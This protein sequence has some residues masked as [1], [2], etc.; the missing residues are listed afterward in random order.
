MPAKTLVKAPPKDPKKIAK[1]VKTFG[2]LSR[3]LTILG[4]FFILLS[5]GPFIQQEFFYYLSQLKKQEFILSITGSTSKKD[6]PNDPPKHLNQDLTTDSPFARLL[7]TRPIALEPV[8]TEF[9]LVIE[10][11]GINVPVVKDVPVSDSDAYM[12]ALE[13]GVAHA[14]VSDYPSTNPGNVYIFAHASLNFWKLGKYATVF[15]LLRHLNLGDSIH[16]FFQDQHFVYKVVGVERYKGWE[17]YPLTRPVLEPILTLQ[18]CDPPGT[19]L[20]RLVVTAKL[21]EVL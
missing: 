11:L 3:F 13:Q 18:T 7:S 4:I 15:N 6:N 12:K 14:L 17:V 8:N 9:A 16:V 5:I 2:F 21:V 19:T 1:K 20:N 10:K